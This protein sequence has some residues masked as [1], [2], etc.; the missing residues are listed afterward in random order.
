LLLA[1]NSLG[2]AKKWNDRRGIPAIVGTLFGFGEYD[3]CL[4]LG[5]SRNL[6]E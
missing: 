3:I 5:I 4:L 6:H 2:Y 1:G